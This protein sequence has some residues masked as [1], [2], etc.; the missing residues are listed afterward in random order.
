MG[1]DDYHNDSVLVLVNDLQQR[2]K[3]VEDFLKIKPKPSGS[4]TTP[5]GSSTYEG[6]GT[7]V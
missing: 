3:V 5:V 6:D 4:T 7:L 2:L 1:M